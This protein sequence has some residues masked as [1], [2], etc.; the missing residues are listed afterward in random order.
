MLVLIGFDGI[1]MF[2]LGVDVPSWYKEE[3]RG[4]EKLVKWIQSYGG[5][6]L[7]TGL[8][9]TMKTSRMV[10]LPLLLNKPV[11]LS[12]PLR[13]LRDQIYSRL[14]EERAFSRVKSIVRVVRAHD[15][16]CPDLARRISN[17]RDKSYLQHLAEH[18]NV[19]RKGVERCFWREEVERAVSLLRHNGPLLI[20]TTHQVGFMLKLLS[21][22]F[23]SE[24]LFIFDEGEDLLLRIGEPL[25][26]EEL[27]YL[28]RISRK[29]YNRLKGLYR[30]MKTGE[31]LGY[32]LPN[33]VRDVFRDSIFVSATF[34]PTL[35]KVLSEDFDGK[36]PVRRMRR[37]RVKDKF[38]ILEKE[39]L[40]KLEDEWAKKLYPQLGLIAEA[41]RRNGYPVGIV[42]RNKEQNTDLTRMFESM[43]YRVWSDAREDNPHPFYNSD[44]VVITTLGKGYRGVN[45]YSRVNRDNTRWDFPVVVGFFQSMGIRIEDIHPV[46]FQLFS[47]NPYK[48][49]K[50]ENSELERFCEEMTYAKNFQ[51]IYRFVR[52]VDRE[53]VI[54]LLDKKWERAFEAYGGDY[55]VRSPKIRIDRE[56]DLAAKIVPL[57]ETIT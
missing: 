23:K 48:D 51:S 2:F 35:I 31:G 53:H 18:E 14:M 12:V 32:I 43:G 57:I 45:Y 3:N 5:V 11:V 47:F 13:Q 10:Y 42:A 28:R 39:L 49:D 27:N 8:P 44:I 55:F 41:A 33:L 17:S 1:N 40:W 54:I 26:L 56:E 21:W 15:E 16:V 20:L 46:F 4:V 25:N 6:G 22:R 19:V 50:E 36:Y 24:S 7:I 52:Q 29:I 38:V 34:P 9:G 30:P 37:K